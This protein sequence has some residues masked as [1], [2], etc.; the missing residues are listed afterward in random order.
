[1]KSQEFLIQ[2][3]VDVAK[4]LELFGDMEMY[5]E[6]LGD[7]MAEISGKL[8]KIKQFKEMGDMENYSIL[9]HSLKSDAKYFGFTTLA[10]LAYEHEL[11]SKENNIV[12][13]NEN[14]DILMQEANKIVIMVKEYLGTPEAAS[15]APVVPSAPKVE[16]NPITMTDQIPLSQVVST[17]D[18]SKGKT[19]LVVDDSPVIKNFIQSKFT[20]RYNVLTAGDG[21]EAIEIMQRNH[22]L[23]AML[24][25]LNM[26]NVDGFEVL[27][28]MKNQDLFTHISVAVVTG[29]DSREL[30]EKAFSYPIVD[31]LKKPFNETSIRNI[32]ERTINFKDN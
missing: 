12:F 31:I 22:N 2:N 5:N 6:S 11:R 7:F 8:F 14:Y 30:D 9:V 4:S 26:P 15:A 10:E 21:K 18:T 25:D 1:M 19:I 3:G 24:L 27:E 20:G 32:V 17:I 23:A 28:Y 13:V 29:N 16:A